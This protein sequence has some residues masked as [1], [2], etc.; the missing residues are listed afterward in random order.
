MHDPMTVAFEIKYP[1]KHY[2]NPTNDFEKKYRDMFITIWHVD[3]ETDGSDDSC[4]WF[5]RSRHGDKNILEKIVKEF[6]FNWDRSWTTEDKLKTYCSGY[7]KS[8]GTMN[9]SV[10]GIVLDL[11][12]RAAYIVFNYNS[13]KTDKYLN[14]NLA[15][16]LH[17]AENPI[18]SLHTS[19]TRKFENACNE[20]YD[21]NKK[22]EWIRNTASVVYGVILRHLRPWYKHPRW[23]IHHWKIQIEPLQRIRRFLFDRCCLCG[24]RFKYN[25]TPLGNWD[26]DKIWHQ[27][28]D[29]KLRP[30]SP[31]QI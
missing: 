30:P 10:H 11:F 6:E 8:D 31:N 12:I 16:I 21:D 14:K 4:G 1:W 22:K 24:K 15:Q 20:A 28:C 17:F 3:P 29:Y 7:F 26:G 13:K 18:D 23:H 19:L 9:M 27:S 25:E 2:K 5:M